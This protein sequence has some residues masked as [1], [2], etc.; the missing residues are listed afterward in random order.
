MIV[1]YEYFPHDY[2]NCPS[3]SPRSRRG[4]TS[5]NKCRRH[6]GQRSWRTPMTATVTRT[7]TACRSQVV[8]WRPTWVSMSRSM[9]TS[10]AT[11][12]VTLSKKSIHAPKSCNVTSV[13]SHIS[14]MP[15]MTTRF[16]LLLARATSSSVTS[17][18]LAQPRSP[19]CVD[20]KR[21]F[22]RHPGLI[23]CRVRVPSISRAIASAEN[24]PVVEVHLG[25][26]RDVVTRDPRFLSER[27]MNS[28]LVPCEYMFDD[29]ACGV[30][31]LDSG[32]KI[33][34]DVAESHAAE[35]D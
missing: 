3:S 17:N 14:Q 18:V 20:G 1:D 7:S 30:L 22:L 29:V 8:S 26:E 32:L 27:L 25:G 23:L 35:V 10:T 28:S 15:S 31:V 33:G 16:C 12:L 34:E 19:C 24:A 5:M 4:R 2:I 21:T 11:S 9:T 6:C 13:G